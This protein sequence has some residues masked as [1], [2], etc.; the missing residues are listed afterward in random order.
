MSVAIG[1]VYLQV[2]PVTG[3]MP[4]VATI[5]RRTQSGKDW[6]I[7]FAER[8]RRVPEHILEDERF[9]LL[10]AEPLSRPALEQPPR[11]Q[12]EHESSDRARAAS[13]G[14]A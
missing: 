9:W 2:T 11:A 14:R 12:L 6:W 8:E 13:S 3:Y 10:I 1:Q 4:I 5:I 7:G